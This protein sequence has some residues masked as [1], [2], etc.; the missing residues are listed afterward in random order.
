MEIF[1]CDVFRGN[2]QAIWLPVLSMTKKTFTAIACLFLL[3]AMAPAAVA[4][5][6]SDSTIWGLSY[7]WGHFEGDVQ[8]MTG[9]DTEATNEDLEAAAEY[10]GF[11]LE[12]DQVLSGASHFYIESWDDS[13]IIEIQDIHGDTHQVS[14]R[15]TEL[16]LR[17]G[18]L[19][20]AG[21]TMAWNDDSESIDIWYSASQEITLVVDATYTEYVDSD[22]LVYGGDLEMTGVISDMAELSM[23]FQV[24]ADGE[25]EDPEIDMGYSLSMEIPSMASEWRVDGPL[26]YLHDLSQQSNNDEVENFYCDNGEVIPADWEND[27]YEDCSD[28]SDE[29][30]IWDC[31]IDVKATSLSSL[32]EGSY[33]EAIEDISPPSWCNTIVPRNLSLDGSQPNLPP[34]EDHYAWY[35][36]QE[37]QIVARTADH[38]W[39]SKIYDSGENYQSESD[40]MDDGGEEWDSSLG[41]CGFSLAGDDQIDSSLIYWETPWGES[42]WNRYQWSG[43]Y[44][45][46]GIP[47]NVTTAGEYEGGII[48]GEFSTLTGYSLSVELNDLPTEDFGINLDAFNVQLSDSIPGQGTF[49]DDFQIS[50]GSIWDWECPPVGG[51]ERLSIDDSMVEVQCGVAPPISPGMAFM[52]GYS[53]MPAFDNGVSELLNVIQSQVESWM[54]EVSGDDE[55]DV[56]LCDNGEE[57]PADWENDGYEDCSDGSDESGGMGTFTCDSGEQIPADWENDGEEDCSDGSDE[58]DG[59]G[60]AESRLEGMIEALMESNLNKTME[61]F[62]EKMAELVEDNVPTEPVMSLEDSCGLLFWN[63]EES[64]VVGMAIMN[65]EDGDG[66]SEVLLGPSIFGVRGHD[67][68]LNIDYN[69]GDSAR[70]VKAEI[71]GLTESEDIAPRSKHNVEELYDILGSEFIPDIDLTDTDLDGVPDVFDQDDD[72]D[73]LFDWED[74]DPLRPFGLPSDDGDDTVP[75]IGVMA[76]SAVLLIAAI[77]SSRRED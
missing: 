17:H 57:I 72:G 24:I 58:N 70:S 49:S 4:V 46:I 73:G 19:A 53:L 33:N 59:T 6:P 11:I 36:E 76:I 67:I 12:S 54:E 39:Y 14:K 1:L 38:I 26:D 32:D 22:M 10:A 61:A 42:G 35:D 74:D 37:D 7:D 23:N 55:S 9:V 43:D 20:D 77:S 40:C 62:G 65:D 44:L 8:N 21:F 13:E 3:S 71:L 28:G 48:E 30:A 5:G 15:M 27:G 34:S 75:G 31:R 2:T 60:E 69:D 29:Y 51:T 18:L 52:M 47:E 41:L 45:F 16:T 56:F 66:S 68:Q 25:V 50:S 63:T 64:R